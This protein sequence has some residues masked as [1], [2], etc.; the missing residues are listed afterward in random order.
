MLVRQSR[1]HTESEHLDTVP[2]TRVAHAG[3][4]GVQTFTCK[5]CGHGQ[6]KRSKGIGSSKPPTSNH[7]HR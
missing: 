5:L 6:W 7:L 1:A 4:D 2:P 3:K